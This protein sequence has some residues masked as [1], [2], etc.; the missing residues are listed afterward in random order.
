MSLETWSQV[1]TEERYSKLGLKLADIMLNCYLN[2]RFCLYIVTGP[3]GVGKSTYALMAADMLARALYEPQSE[4]CCL[5]VDEHVLFTIEELITKVRNTYRKLLELCGDSNS[6]W[7]FN[8]LPVLIIDDAG[9][10]FNKYISRTNIKL[11]EAVQGTLHTLRLVVA[12]MILTTPNYRDILKLLR[13]DADTRVVTVKHHSVVDNTKYS[14][15]EISSL[16][17][18]KLKDGNI[19]I[20]RSLATADVFPLEAPCYKEYFRKRTQILEKALEQL[21]RTAKQGEKMV[22]IGENGSTVS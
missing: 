2:D 9:V 20:T 8:R 6:C 19:M 21:Q 17:K 11:V 7:Q 12:N 1:G 13:E 16:P 22:E 10:F 18:V 5:D 4:E 3:R 14:M 15:A